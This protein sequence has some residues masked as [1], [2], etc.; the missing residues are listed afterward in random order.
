[1]NSS[2][3]D[4]RENRLQKKEEV[5]RVMKRMGTGGHD[6]DGEKIDSPVASRPVFFFDIDNCVSMLQQISFIILR[7]CWSDVLSLFVYLA[8]LLATSVRSD[9]ISQ[10]TFDASFIVVVSLAS[11]HGLSKSKVTRSL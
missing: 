9:Q 10:L 1:M 2:G 6:D 5:S 11:Q 7:T 3:Q 8:F 4:T